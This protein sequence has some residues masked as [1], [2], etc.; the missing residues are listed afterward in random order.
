MKQSLFGWTVKKVEMSKLY[1]VPF[2]TYGNYLR[3][4]GVVARE[5]RTC[6][7]EQSNGVCLYENILVNGEKSTALLISH[8]K[9]TVFSG[10]PAG[11]LSII[12]N[13]HGSTLYLNI[14]IP[15]NAVAV[16]HVSP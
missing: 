13:L 14:S 11:N 15:L 1:L 5:V 12:L 9:Q 16:P 2:H 10:H 8:Y 6:G 7:D 3:S 4:G